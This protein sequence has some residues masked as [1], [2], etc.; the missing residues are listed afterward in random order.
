MRE[1]DRNHAH[2]VLGHLSFCK[3]VEPEY[4]N[5]LLAKYASYG[6]AVSSGGVMPALVELA[7]GWLAGDLL[8]ACDGCVGLLFEPSRIGCIFY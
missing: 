7:Y 6:K 1:C 4:C 8:A 3:Q 2:R 5:A